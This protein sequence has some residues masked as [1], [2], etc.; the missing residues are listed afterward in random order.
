MECDRLN[1]CPFFAD[2]MA[3]MP[4]VA[5]VVKRMYCL[6]DK[7]QCARYQLASAGV[8]VPPDPFPKPKDTARARDLLRHR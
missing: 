4:N 5:E 6:G 8:A 7:T 2:R 3:N 1:T